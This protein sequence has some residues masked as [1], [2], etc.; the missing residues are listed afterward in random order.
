[1]HVKHGL[2]GGGLERGLAGQHV[3]EDGRQAVG[4]RTLVSRLALSLLGRKVGWVADHLVRS[5]LCQREVDDLHVTGGANQHVLGRHIAMNQSG[6]LCLKQ[7]LAD[8][9]NHG[10]GVFQVDGTGS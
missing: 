7:R 6:L 5:G 1:M 2:R 10:L 4:V 9:P 3:I 8:L